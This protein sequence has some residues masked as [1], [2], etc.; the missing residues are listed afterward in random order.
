MDNEVTILIRAKNEEEHIGQ[1][2]KAICNQSFKDFEIILIDSGSTD[3]TLEIVKDFPVKV[4]H[5]APEDF[6]YGYSTNYGFELSKGKYI[7][8]LSAHAVPFSDDWLQILIESFSDEEVAAVMGRDIPFP[9]CNP[10]DKR[11]M[12]KLYDVPRSEIDECSFDFGATNAAVRRSVWGEIKF[13]EKLS[14]AEDNDWGRHVK[15]KGYRIIYEPGAV[16]YHSHNDSYRQMVRRFCNE[17][18]ALR[19]LNRKRYSW[20][21]IYVDFF[22]GT[23]YDMLY[24]LI[25]G[26]QL[27]WFFYAPIRRFAMNYGR[28]LAR[29]R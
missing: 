22:A 16:V 6:T 7:V 14:Y 1:T 4:G 21:N 2:L 28:L 26:E 24:V 18:Y 11:G 27:K 12:L 8:C 29:Y 5:I 23:V 25:K 20:L 15:A 3:R 10:F 9:D 17:A 13:D 19:L